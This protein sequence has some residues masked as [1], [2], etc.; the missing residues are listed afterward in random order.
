MYEVRY[1]K[2]VAKFLVK[3]DTYIFEKFQLQVKLLAKNPSCNSLDIKNLKNSSCYRL[4][5]GKYR[6]LYEIIDQQMIIYFVK[7]DSRGGVY[8]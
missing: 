7:A 5:I 4:R 3:C 2:R 6:F 1:S 8:K